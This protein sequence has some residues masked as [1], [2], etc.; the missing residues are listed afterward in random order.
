M[1]ISY[2]LY[3]AP[4]ERASM[5]TWDKAYSMPIDTPENVMKK[6]SSVYPRI[7]KWSSRERWSTDPSNPYVA[8]YYTLGENN[9]DPR[10]EYIDINIIQHSDG[11]IHW[12][13]I[14]KGS[15]KLVSEIKALFNLKYVFE[16]QSCRLLDPDKY[17]GNWE[18]I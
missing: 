5:N 2:E 17:K 8:S 10:N 7:K 11:F 14:R 18:P 15:P 4:E 6:L 3:N 12:I 9:C 1:S 16:G 13:S